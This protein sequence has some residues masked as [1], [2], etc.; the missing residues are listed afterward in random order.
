MARRNLGSLPAVR[1]GGGASAVV[2]SGQRHAGFGVPGAA[3]DRVEGHHRAGPRGGPRLV[4]PDDRGGLPAGRGGV[5]QFSVRRGVPPSSVAGGAGRAG[6]G[7]AAGLRAGR[8]GRGGRI[9]AVLGVLGAWRG[10]VARA[11]AGTD[12][13]GR[14]PFSGAGAW[15]AGRVVVH[16]AGGRGGAGRHAGGPRGAG[17]LRAVRRLRRCGAVDAGWRSGVLGRGFTGSHRVRSAGGVWS[18]L[19]GS[20]HP[21]PGG[22][23]SFLVG[24]VGCVFAAGR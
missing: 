21:A 4:R 11:D 6:G 13:G 15:R 12:A 19:G 14:D 9:R 10:G 3:A 7:G 5:R 23:Q 18:L 20:R 22:V 24:P 16:L 17:S 8:L 1:G 2:Q